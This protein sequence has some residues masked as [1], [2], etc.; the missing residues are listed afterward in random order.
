MKTVVGLYRSLAEAYKVKST[1]QLKGY[2][3]AHIHVIDQTTG[4]KKDEPLTDKVK[5]FFSNFIDHKDEH[6][7]YADRIGSGGA[8]LSVTVPDEEAEQTADL[9]Y[10]QGAT[11]IKEGRTS[12]ESGKPGASNSQDSARGEAV[13]NDQVIP[14]VQEE[15]VVGRREVDRGGVRVYSHVVETPATA[16]VALRDERVVVDRRAV[17]RP[18]SEADFAIAPAVIEVHA[19]GE[20]A[21]VGRTGRV[22]EEVRVSKQA[23]ERTEQ[24]HDVVR[25]TEVDVEPTTAETGK[26]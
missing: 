16:S 6:T 26:L 20:E 12:A 22:V 15:L 4:M 5:E 18:A 21:V 13:A 23:G 17:D 3:A 10:E 1:L 2:H 11:G 19:K 25:R 8:L 24:I 9:L 7:H 14:I